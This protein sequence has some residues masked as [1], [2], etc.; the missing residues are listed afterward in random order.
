MLTCSVQRGFPKAVVQ[1][2]YELF[3]PFLSSVISPGRFKDF[4]QVVDSIRDGKQ[5]RVEYTHD[6]TW[7]ELDRQAMTATLTQDH[8]VE[9][10]SQSATMPLELFCSVAEQW[11]RFVEEHPAPRPGRTP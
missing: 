9:D 8:P 11:I 6:Y 5:D 10:E 7:L 2:P 1:Q 3:G 4:R